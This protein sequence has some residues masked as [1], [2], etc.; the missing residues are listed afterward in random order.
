M[1]VTTRVRVL[2]V[3]DADES[4][5]I[6]R[7]ALAFDEAI[8][9]VGEASSGGEAVRQAET[10]RP[11][12]ILMDVRMPEGNGINA[13][14]E[15][16]RRLPGVRVLALTAHDD[17]DSVRDMLAAGATGY[18]V[19][20]APVDEVTTAIRKT[21]Q[22]HAQLDQRI[23][24]H[25]LDDLR[26]MIQEERDRRAEAER[27]ATTRQ[28]LIQVLSHELRTPLTLINAALRSLDSPG[29]PKNAS[30]LVSAAIKRSA[31]LERV[32]EGLEV[33]AEG[34]AGRGEAANPVE[35]VGRV[36]QAVPERPELIEALDENWPGLYTHHV[37]RVAIELLDNSAKHG[38]SPVT[39]RL[40]REGQHG[41]VEVS[42]A[43][44]F[45]PD[46][47]LFGPF[48]QGDMSTRREQGGFGLGLFVAARLCEMSGGWID[49]RR[50][51]D[52]T[53]AQGRFELA[54]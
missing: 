10:L 28:E 39:L 24:H 52:R 40:F 19:K 42:D 2:V 51:N 17:Q 50:E 38:R 29:L 30:E 21:H 4:R 41:V 37:A 13:T 6:L 35:A 9:V 8:E 34:P 33:L 11:D 49:I 7:R 44:S 5:D 27:L 32:V 45:E 31:E 18:L 54:S 14:R 23:V 15:I 46:P 53:V 36:L 25:I 48:V 3:D 1:A 12:V 43:G 47:R 16:T 22:G 26:T 20:G